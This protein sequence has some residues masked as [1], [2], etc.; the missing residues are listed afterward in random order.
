VSGRAAATRIYSVTLKGRS[1]LP[2][3]QKQLLA[4]LCRTRDALQ[5]HITILEKVLSGRE[6]DTHKY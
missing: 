6:N 5:Q 4:E 3:I 1:K 2:I